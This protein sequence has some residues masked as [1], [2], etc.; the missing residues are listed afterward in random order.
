VLNRTGTAVLDVGYQ[1]APQLVQCPEKVIAGAVAGDVFVF[2]IG[3]SGYT[4]SN[5]THCAVFYNLSLSCVSDPLPPSAAATYSSS[6]SSGQNGQNGAHS[7]RD[8]VVFVAGIAVLAALM[9]V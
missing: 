4:G 6:S 3:C 1:V 7:A 8:A 9:L 5:D 2:S